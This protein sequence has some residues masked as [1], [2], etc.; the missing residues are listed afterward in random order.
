[1][2]GFVLLKNGL[3]VTVAQLWAQQA[4]AALNAAVAK[5]LTLA[6][7]LKEEA[8][9]SSLSSVLICRLVFIPTF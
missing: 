1:M 8:D 4:E 9:Y 2:F 5:I 6:L 3:M 7:S